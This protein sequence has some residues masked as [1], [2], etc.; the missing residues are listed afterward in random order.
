MDTPAVIDGVLPAKSRCEKR[1]RDTQTTYVRGHIFRT[2]YT[3]PAARLYT[4]DKRGRFLK[5]TNPTRDVRHVGE[6]EGAG[7]VRDLPHAG[8]VVQA[9]VRRGVALQV[10]FRKAKL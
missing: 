10:A 6:E 7:L 3:V 8:V 5:R 1:E 2:T 9:R 4:Q